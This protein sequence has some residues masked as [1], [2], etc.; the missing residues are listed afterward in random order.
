MLIQGLDNP[1]LDDEDTE[2]DRR[3]NVVDYF[4]RTFRT[5]NSYVFKFIFCELLNL[6]NILFQVS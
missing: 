4:M 5:H 3:A 6:V 1:C 2:K